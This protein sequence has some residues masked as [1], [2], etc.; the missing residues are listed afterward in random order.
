MQVEDGYPYP[1]I[2][3][4]EQWALTKGVAIGDQGLKNPPLTKV[5][6]L[7]YRFQHLNGQIKR[8]SIN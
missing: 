8:T 5:L 2:E 7:L 4:M 6:K 3:Q 1:P